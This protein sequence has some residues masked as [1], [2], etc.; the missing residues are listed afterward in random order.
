MCL[1]HIHCASSTQLFL[2]LYTEK[3][4]PISDNL[5]IEK[6]PSVDKNTEFPSK[7]PSHKGR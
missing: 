4:F 7:P 5:S 6:S 1:N 3:Y 2:F